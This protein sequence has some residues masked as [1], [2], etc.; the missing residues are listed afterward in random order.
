MQDIHIQVPL[1]RCKDEW[2]KEEDEET[3]AACLELA[4][5]IKELLSLPKR[6]DEGPHGRNDSRRLQDCVGEM[7]E[8]LT[9]SVAA[10]EK[11]QL[12]IER[13]SG[14]LMRERDM[15]ATEDETFAF[16]KE[17]IACEMWDDC[18]NGRQR[19]LQTS[20]GMHLFVELKTSSQLC[21]RSDIETFRRDVYNM[22]ASKGMNAAFL[23][24]LN[25]T[26]IPNKRGCCSIDFINGKDG[27]RVPIVMLSNNLK[28][29][30]ALAL[31]SLSSICSLS[32]KIHF[33][34]SLLEEEVNFDRLQQLDHARGE[35]GKM[36]PPLYHCMQ[37]VAE[38]IEKR[39]SALRIL[40]RDACF[41]K[42]MTT[43]ATEGIMKLQEA[44]GVTPIHAQQPELEEEGCVIAVDLITSLELAKGKP[45][46]TSDMTKS[47]RSII[48]QAGGMKKVSRM[49]SKR[50]T[51]LE[52]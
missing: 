46:C 6:A 47:Q 30:I 26:M 14:L 37:E 32:K 10:N 52:R 49:L 43:K 42:E 4:G 19:H 7:A 29:C 12:E 20:E 25:S 15:V 2:W 17:S 16:M 23:L 8:R 40:E 48:K 38:T 22:T 13:L 24:S 45:I 41:E 21:T 11:K 3:V 35:I 27:S 18:S 31:A 1:G 5:N 50:Q 36:L 44:L 34:S 39:V 51:F 9:A 28:P 33:M